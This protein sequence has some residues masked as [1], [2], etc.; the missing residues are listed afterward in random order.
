LLRPVS[1]WLFRALA[2]GL[3]GLSIGL[4]VLFWRLA[5]AGLSLS[6]VTPYVNAGLEEA[7]PGYRIT[8]GD[9]EL[10]WQGFDAPLGVRAS[11]VRVALSTGEAAAAVIPRLHLDLA[12]RPLLGGQLRV[13]GAEAIGA[14]LHLT[15]SRDGAVG[16]AVRTGPVDGG[17][18]GPGGRWDLRQDQAGSAASGP[19]A[20]EE[21]PEEASEGSDDAVLAR[22]VAQLLE[23]PSDD[24]I[25]AALDSVGV[26]ESR[27]VID[28]A[29]S[30]RSWQAD[31]VWLAAERRPTGIEMRG[32][33]VLDLGG[34]RRLPLDVRAFHRLQ[35][36]GAEIRIS[37]GPVYP[38]ELA[39]ATSDWLRMLEAPL[40]FEAGFR[41]EGEGLPAAIDG[42]ISSPLGRLRL[43]SL[44]AAPLP[45]SDL[46]LRFQARPLEQRLEV[47][48]LT[49]DLAG[50]RV[51]GRGEVLV[52]AVPSGALSD[53][54]DA[55]AK[56]QVSAASWQGR[57]DGI[58]H[59]QILDG[60]FHLP[61]A[62]PGEILDED[63]QMAL[64]LPGP[65][66]LVMTYASGRGVGQ[67]LHLDLTTAQGEVSVPEQFDHWLA[68][69]DVRLALAYDPG[70]SR[71][72]L[73]EGRFAVDEVPVVASGWIDL[74]DGAAD[75]EG[76]MWRR[77]RL[78]AEVGDLD[79]S[80]FLPLWP[81][82]L[83]P[84][85]R[86]WFADHLEAAT[87]LDPKLVL[88]LDARD[89]ELG[90]LSEGSVDLRFGVAEA[91]VHHLRPMAPIRDLS[92][93][94][95]L[96]QDRF[97]LA[98]G[99]G[100]IDGV[101]LV[102]G[103][104]VAS[105]LQSELPRME[106]RFGA[107]GRIAPILSV[108]DQPP[109][110]FSRQ[111]GIAP[112]DLG[113][114][115]DLDVLLQFP[116]ME[117]LEP[118][119]VLFA[120]AGPLTGVTMSA[121][122]G[123]LALTEGNL[124]F[125][126]NATDLEARGEGRLAGTPAQVSWRQPLA[127]GQPVSY[128]VAARLDEAWRRQQGFDLAPFLTGPLHATI[129]FVEDPDEGWQMGASLDLQETRLSVPAL[130]LDKPAG[131]PANASLRGRIVG[132]QL[133]ALTIDNLVAPDLEL[134]A[135]LSFVS[136]RIARIDLARLWYGGTRLSGWARL[137]PEGIWSGLLQG[138]SADLRPY[139]D[140]V[141]A[142]EPSAPAGSGATAGAEGGLDADIV[143]NVAS[144]QVTDEFSV[145]NLA[146]E[147]VL[148]DGEVDRLEAQA[149]LPPHEGELDSAISTIRLRMA[150][151]GTDLRYALNSDDAGRAFRAMGFDKL[152]GGSLVAVGSAPA[153]APGQVT[154]RAVVRDTRIVDVPRLQALLA[155]PGEQEGGNG[156][157]A[158]GPG[159]QAE[160]VRVDLAEVDARLL[161]QALRLDSLRARGPGV[162]LTM[163]GDLGLA[164]DE[165]ALTGTFVPAYA[166]NR[167][168]GQI[169]II[170]DLLISR[171]G[172]GLIGFTF[173]AT[174]SLSD[175]QV[176]VNP[177][178]G[179]APGFLRRLFEFTAPD[180]TGGGN[181]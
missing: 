61:P 82:L 170:G 77:A 30:G 74:A 155:G 35:S 161:G 12:L 132:E 72:V 91:V 25:L 114:V 176:E 17:E 117:D 60:Q 133:D 148:R 127:P 144:A 110:T 38:S 116:V 173:R 85:T 147:A 47:T 130:H 39:D 13:T 51:S 27:L 24:G 123:G 69:R 14:L 42:R 107:Q 3:A 56:A 62:A 166:V 45:L 115:A 26:S 104:L 100:R 163:Q 75:G 136:G 118:E 138:A 131:A 43:P 149:A 113:G 57:I 154:A 143:L 54:G 71:L 53:L 1:K 94:A 169:P 121:M 40:L 93:V 98:D 29:V 86:Q 112:A 180:L 109:L 32:A 9:T 181:G 157:G 78:V 67:R 167:L 101:R 81:K 160:G 73:R 153:S 96:T 52:D 150:R 124:Q 15:R 165:V 97:T 119:D 4:A 7:V 63:V 5:T 99:T 145:A 137:E 64:S 87:I 95:H 8:L 151:D 22:L 122:L 18:G 16:L 66:D 177:L 19:E 84:P 11:D 33:M 89:M 92:A 162:G 141:T 134:G 20:P 36:D 135:D 175:P 159:L 106:I 10:Y 58:P 168:F 55:L 125:S 156:R 65:L 174:G 76:P 129:T 126:A 28:D 105:D 80:Q 23:E 90:E 142:A 37:G 83:V 172:E 21:V 120:V 102:A 88:E 41:L 140:G 179:L 59:L 103:E 164:V 48:A 139:L 6:F 178:S 79:Q 171:E 128:R 68:L 34:E 111:A 152:R 46:D 44:T 49:V 146:L 158:A 31:R 2:A 50:S 70:E 108:L